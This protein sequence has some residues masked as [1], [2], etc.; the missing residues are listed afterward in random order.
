MLGLG[1]TK[2][3]KNKSCLKGYTRSFAGNSMSNNVSHTYLTVGC[4]WKT[5][6]PTYFKSIKC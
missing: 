6:S 3:Q 1:W 4:P 2:I 5:K